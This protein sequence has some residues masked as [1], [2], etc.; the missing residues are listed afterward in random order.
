MN[1]SSN[2]EMKNLMCCFVS[3]SKLEF[4]FKKIRTFLLK[5]FKSEIL[6]SVFFAENFSEEFVD[7]A[8]LLYFY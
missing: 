8:N 1:V 6:L 3:A 4:R 7:P 2:I 5:M